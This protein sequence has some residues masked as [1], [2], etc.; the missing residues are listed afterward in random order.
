MCNKC[1]YYILEAIF[2]MLFHFWTEE[3]LVFWWPHLNTQKAFVWLVR[4]R[5]FHLTEL[6]FFGMGRNLFSEKSESC[7][8]VRFQLRDWWGFVAQTKASMSNL[9]VVRIT[10]TSCFSRYDPPCFSF[11]TRRLASC[12]EWPCRQ[13]RWTIIQNGSTFI[14]R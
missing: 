10:S 5:S 7:F 3:S 4:T 9:L 13:R 12:Q 6:F 11:P 1:C 2:N 14:I 8:L